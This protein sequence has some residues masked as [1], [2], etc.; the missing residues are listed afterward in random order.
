M[1]IDPPFCSVASFS[2]VSLTPFINKPDYSRDLTIFII[3]PISSFENINVVM[4]GQKVFLWIDAF[5]ADAVVVNPS[6]N[7]T[8]LANGLSTFLINGETV[9]EVYSEIFLTWAS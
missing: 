1:L 2:I 8:L 3:S 9:E 7:K 6:G 4:I 5:I